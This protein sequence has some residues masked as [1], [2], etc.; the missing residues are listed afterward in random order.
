MC[1]LRVLHLAQTSVFSPADDTAEADFS[2]FMNK[3]PA[4][5]QYWPKAINMSD[6]ACRCPEKHY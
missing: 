4:K 6:E 1:I 3:I 2:Q 5:D